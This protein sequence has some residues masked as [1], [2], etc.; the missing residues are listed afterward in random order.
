MAIELVQSNNNRD[1]LRA[2]LDEIDVGIVLLDSNLNPQ[3]FNRAFLR[4]YRVT[5]AS[6]VAKLN[7][8]GLLRLVVGKRRYLSSPAK[9]STNSCRASLSR[10]VAAFF[11]IS[12]LHIDRDQPV[13]PAID[14]HRN[15]LGGELPAGVAL[16][17]GEVGV[18]NSATLYELAIAAVPHGDVGGDA[19]AGAQ[20]GDGR[21]AQINRHSLA[22]TE[23][24]RRATHQPLAGSVQA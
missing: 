10:V 5:D 9:V 11:A 6:V 8:E 14:S 16:D 17:L 22:L 13:G 3:F 15:L 2:A 23:A 7:F 24:L 1:T 12:I 19:R 18:R 4:I 21:C 20:A